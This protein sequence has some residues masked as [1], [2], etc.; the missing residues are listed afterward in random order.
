MKTITLV[1]AGLTCVGC[2]FV[3]PTIDPLLIVSK[4]TVQPAVASVSADQDL[5]FQGRAALKIGATVQASV[6][7]KAS[8]KQNPD[9]IDAR[10]GMVAVL[11]EQERYEEA[12]DAIRVIRNLAPDDLMIARNESQILAK[13]NRSDK[14]LVPEGKEIAVALD[15]TNGVA[16][17]QPLTLPRGIVEVKPSAE[18]KQLAPNVFELTRVGEQVVAK[19]TSEKKLPVNLKASAIRHQTKDPSVRILVSNGSGK[20]GLACG[21][22]KAFR[23]SSLGDSQVTSDCLNH[24]NFS[25]ARTVLYVRKGSNIDT[26]ALLSALGSKNK[27]VVTRSETLPQDADAQLI[28]GR[29]WRAAPTYTKPNV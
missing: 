17:L 19:A 6:F 23:A 14:N 3:G 9:S 25:Q 7:F 24:T 20:T 28:I 5:Y 2:A 18:I 15:P 10:N 1:F 26:I 4:T 22:A 27:F 13:V 29:D 12:L 21:Q 16:L 8:L 11:F